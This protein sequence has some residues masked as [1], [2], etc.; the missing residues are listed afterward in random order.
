MAQSELFR[1][2]QD[3]FLSSISRPFEYPLLQINKTANNLISC[4][5][6]KFFDLPEVQETWK[7]I[8][9]YIRASDAYRPGDHLDFYLKTVHPN[10][11]LMYNSTMDISFTALELACSADY[12][13]SRDHIYQTLESLFK[14]GANPNDYLF[15]SPLAAICANKALTPADKKQFISLMID[16][17]VDLKGFFLQ[18]VDRPV[19]QQRFGCCAQTG[20]IQQDVLQ[21]IIDALA[22]KQKVRG[23]IKGFFTDIYNC[24]Q[25][26]H[27]L[28]VMIF[29]G[30]DA[31]KMAGEIH[32]L[33]EIQFVATRKEIV[34]KA[35]AIYEQAKAQF[36]EDPKINAKCL[37][38]HLSSMS[39]DVVGF[40][41]AYANIDT[42][43]QMIA[44]L[45]YEIASK[46]PI[47]IPVL[48]PDT[49]EKVGLHRNLD[50]KLDKR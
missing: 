34:A 29:N 9:L 41:A 49:I 35:L 31:S 33:T 43:R 2:F 45:C 40:I 8:E 6:K 12:E 19:K 36:P 46:D 44:R 10:L 3:W 26:L 32:A 14:A 11:C 27:L 48:F 30:I 37:G 21:M 24:D 7:K 23:A 13:R 4:L 42:R 18:F 1:P 5:H 15:F 50:R 16:R 22:H 47:E 25:C 39:L 17:N 28:P 38:H 20:H